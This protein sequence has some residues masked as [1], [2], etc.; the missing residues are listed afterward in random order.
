MRGVALELTVHDFEV[1]IFHLKRVWCLGAPLQSLSAQ[2][3]SQGSEFDPDGQRR[4]RTHIPVLPAVP[5]P[6]II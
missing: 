4:L 2:V 3:L 1:G 6:T 5:A